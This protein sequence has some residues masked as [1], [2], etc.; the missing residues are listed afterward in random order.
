M[1]AARGRERAG[2]EMELRDRRDSSAAKERARRDIQT[3][4]TITTEGRITKWG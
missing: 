1:G 4:K 3:S 2:A